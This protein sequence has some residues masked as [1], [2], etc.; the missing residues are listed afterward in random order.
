MGGT[1]QKISQFPPLQRNLCALSRRKH[2]VNSGGTELSPK[3]I[4]RSARGPR[5]HRR[6]G[7]GA[8]PGIVFSPS[9][10]LI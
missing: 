2:R 4:L 10:I 9:L 1:S 3:R 6:V 8:L 7:S 5:G